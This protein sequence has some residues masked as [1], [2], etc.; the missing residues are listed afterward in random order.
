MIVYSISFLFCL[1]GNIT[2]AKENKKN[3][4]IGEFETIIPKIDINGV[5]ENLYKEF[6]NQEK[7]FDRFVIENKNVLMDL[8]KE[9]EIEPINKDN[10]K[11]YHEVIKSRYNE[12]FSNLEYKDMVEFFDIF[13]NKEKNELIKDKLSKNDLSHMEYLLPFDSV[14]VI[15]KLGNSTDMDNLDD[16]MLSNLKELGISSRATNMPNMSAAI[17]YA[18]KYAENPNK[19]E[20]HYFRNGDWDHVAF[21][22]AA[23]NYKSDYS[24]KTY[25][26]YKVAQHTSN[27]LA[28]TSSEKNGWENLSGRYAIIRE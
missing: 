15:E 27:Y 18:K 21:V 8:S 9:H 7:E 10:W 25:Y 17:D 5:S 19:G 16:E 2:G 22:V 14:F 24:G 20:Y 12:D 3:D 13:E 1:S 6:S 4:S 23:D 28:W 26:D 11:F